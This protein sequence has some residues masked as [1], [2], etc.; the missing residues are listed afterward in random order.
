MP[1]LTHAELTNQVDTML[2]NG[3]DYD[4]LYDL[5]EEVAAYLSWQPA[6]TAPTDTPL[7]ATY[8]DASGKPKIIRAELIGRFIQEASPAW[9][10]VEYDITADCWYR[11]PGWVELMDHWD[12]HDSCYIN[13]QIIGW[14][15]L[16]KP[17]EQPA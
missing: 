3:G 14:M 11:E 8:L 13:A 5:L 4:E 17:M 10:C 9:D 16:P 15:P 12:D 1:K 7:L 2:E 6:D